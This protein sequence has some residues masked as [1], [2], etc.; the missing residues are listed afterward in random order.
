MVR[1]KIIPFL[2]D[3]QGRKRTNLEVAAEI[4]CSPETISRT[5]R[6]LGIKKVPGQSQERL[7]AKKRLTA[8]RKQFRGESATT[9]DME[10]AM[11]VTG[12]SK[13]SIYRWRAKWKTTA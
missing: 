3:L 5:L 4:G 13:R 6:Q 1:E 11:R 8:A 10:K 2:S 12:L 7:N 9:L